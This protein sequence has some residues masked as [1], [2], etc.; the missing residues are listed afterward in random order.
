MSRPKKIALIVGGSFA[1][2]TVRTKLVKTDPKLVSVQEIVM[3]VEPERWALGVIVT[4]LLDP[5]PPNT[6]F[7]L[8]TSH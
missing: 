1:G 6:I 4:V 3:V 2:E 7:V 5:E 8:A